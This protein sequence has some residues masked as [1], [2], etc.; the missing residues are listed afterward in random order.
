MR[1]NC[2]TVCDDRNVQDHPLD[3]T[4]RRLRVSSSQFKQSVWDIDEAQDFLYECGWM[5]VSDFV[6]EIKRH[7]HLSS[8]HVYYTYRMVTKNKNTAG[9]TAF[10]DHVYVCHGLLFAVEPGYICTTVTA[11]LNSSNT[12]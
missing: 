1:A 4:F 12:F 6:T 5:P 11:C 9:D 7:F 10:P 2:L 8:I 3:D